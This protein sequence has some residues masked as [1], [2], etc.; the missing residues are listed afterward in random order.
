MERVCVP[1]LRSYLAR[2]SGA[3]LYSCCLVYTIYLPTNHR[4]SPE[5]RL[6]REE[7]RGRKGQPEG[8]A[9]RGRAISCF[10][11]LLS[12]GTRREIQIMRLRAQAQSREPRAE[13][14]ASSLVKIHSAFCPQRQACMH[15]RKA[16]LL[17]PLCR[18]SAPAVR[19]NLFCAQDFALSFFHRCVLCTYMYLYSCTC[20]FVTR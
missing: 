4:V 13:S 16:T 1:S 14:G 7:P 5:A 17:R 10:F 8:C 18:P 12:N 6:Q 3:F 11:S 9:R 20:L 15:V 2:G 19:S